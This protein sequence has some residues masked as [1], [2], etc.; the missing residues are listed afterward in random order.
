[1]NNLS[2]VIVGLGGIGTALV[3]PICQFL[4]FYK[5]GLA[6]NEDFAREMG[7]ENP[8]I[9]DDI[10][11]TLVDGDVYEFR[12]RER[13]EF[14]QLGP[15]S[16]VKER[17]LRELYPAL[18]YNSINQYITEDNISDII[19]DGDIVFIC[20]DNHPSRKLINNYCKT[21]SNIHVF[22]GGNSFHTASAKIHSK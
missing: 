2:I 4:H 15:K 11:V 19:K 1:M 13:Q 17:D 22:S 12:N 21:L 9:F 6:T 14:S 5:S 3:T 7:V 16:E 20:V 8:P 18:S 10:N